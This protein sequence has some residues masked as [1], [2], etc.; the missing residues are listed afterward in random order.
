MIGYNLGKFFIFELL[1]TILSLTINS[2][3]HD[4]DRN[5]LKSITRLGTTVRIILKVVG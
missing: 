3:A 4:V 5:R 1:S 2:F